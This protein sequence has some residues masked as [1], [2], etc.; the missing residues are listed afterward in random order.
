MVTLQQEYFFIC[1][2]VLQED[3]QESLRRP[4]LPLVEHQSEPPKKR[5][6]KSA[7]YLKAS[8]RKIDDMDLKG[9]KLSRL[10]MKKRFE[11]QQ[12]R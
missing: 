7:G 3:Q 12:R 5:G 10:K 1:L 4:Q 6:K 8:K 9:L 2:M 11:N